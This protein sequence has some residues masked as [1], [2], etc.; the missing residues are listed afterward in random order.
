[1]DVQVS[2]DDI[3]CGSNPRAVA[4]R[5]EIPNLKAFDDD[6]PWLSAEVSVLVNTDTVIG[7]TVTRDYDVLTGIR[8]KYDRGRTRA[9]ISHLEHEHIKAVG[10]G[11]NFCVIASPYGNHI[12]GNGLLAGFGKI[13]PRCRSTVLSA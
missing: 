13:A 3:G 1:M 4:L 10:T 8:T 5:S 6:K 9:A 7:A 11:L 2:K 12:T